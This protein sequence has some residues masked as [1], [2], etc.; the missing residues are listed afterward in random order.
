MSGS[1]TPSLAA[2]YSV[3]RAVLNAAD[4][5]QPMPKPA[6]MGRS[7]GLCTSV[8]HAALAALHDDGTIT[9]RHRGMRLVVRYIDGTETA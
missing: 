4:A 9:M 8:V 2:R 1:Y 7:I 3:L 5:G 6:I